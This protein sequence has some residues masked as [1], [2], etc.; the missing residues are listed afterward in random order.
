[1][2]SNTTRPPCLPPRRGCVCAWVERGQVTTGLRV[3]VCRPSLSM[4]SSIKSSELLPDFEVDIGAI[5]FG[6]ADKLTWAGGSYI[7]PGRDGASY[8][9]VTFVSQLQRVNSLDGGAQKT[10]ITA[11]IKGLSNLLPSNP[12]SHGMPPPGLRVGPN[13][14]CQTPRFLPELAGI[15]QTTVHARGLGNNNLVPLW[16]LVVGS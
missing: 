11:G 6:S 2:A 9:G 15:W 13:P 4:L 5:S 16:G 10:A 8:R 7:Q 12:S 1:M 14:L 3:G